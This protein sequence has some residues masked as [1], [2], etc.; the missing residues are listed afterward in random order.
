[1][2]AHFLAGTLLFKR[3]GHRERLEQGGNCGDVLA[4]PGEHRG[5]LSVFHYFPVD[6]ARM[7]ARASPV[8]APPELP[9]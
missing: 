1:M 5:A 9:L 7:G 2:L 6:L 3:C 4:S 8:G